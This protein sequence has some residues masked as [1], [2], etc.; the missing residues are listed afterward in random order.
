MNLFLASSMVRHDSEIRLNICK[1]G[2][3]NT[4]ILEYDGRIDMK[5]QLKKHQLQ[6]VNEMM[7]LENAS[8]LMEDNEELYTEM[9]VLG[10]K[11]GSGKTF[12]ILALIIIKKQLE[13]RLFVKHKLGNSVC[14][15]KK[16]S[17]IKPCNLI[18]SPH[19]ILKP[20]WETYIK[21]YTNLTYIVINKNNIFDW[22]GI[23]K[24]DIVLCNSR[25][26]NKFIKECPWTWSRVIYD[27]A[28]TI[29][30][31]ACVYPK[32]KFVWFVSSSLKNLLFP[33]GFYSFNQSSTTSSVS[34]KNITEGLLHN[35][36]IKDTFR[37]FESVGIANN[38]LKHIVLKQCDDYIDEILQLPDFENIFYKCK[39]S[40]LVNVL[41]HVV[42][43]EMINMM[44]AN[45]YEGVL[46][47]LGCTIDTKENIITLVCKDINNKID[48][49]NAKLRYLNSLNIRNNE[50]ENHA[51]K[52]KS[53]TE[54]IDQLK[55]RI[56]TIEQRVSNLHYDILTDTCPICLDEIDKKSCMLKCC[57]NVFCM[58]CIGNL[59]QQEGNVSKKCPMCRT[60]I[61]LKDILYLTK[62]SKDKKQKVN[63]ERTKEECLLD[64]IQSS[65]NSKFLI[66]SSYD[67]SFF[68]ICQMLS[69]NDLT[70][71][72]L[73]GN[74]AT[75]NSRLN[76]FNTDENNILMLNA[77]HYGCG[78][79][80][81][82]ATDL[83]FFHKMNT[84][85]KS[86]VIGRA[87]RLGRTT[88]LKVHHLYY[89]NEFE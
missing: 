88:N 71:A 89:E 17:D 8:I 24:Y 57:M 4:N 69:Q 2:T 32:Y 19:H 72:K 21:E 25:L 50:R 64:I 51:H 58:K 75:I 86:Q 60:N 14:I 46:E 11:V 36:F 85:I 9:G 10:N 7:K 80:L 23:Q 83:V 63:K 44:N 87:Q 1:Y 33:N 76:N 37:S 55:E 78:L 66:F 41:N 42:G 5:I 35:G 26:H 73:V 52:I 61:E 43:A 48:N 29:S 40:Y 12:C 28:D 65:P 39:N 15:M 77:S 68:K 18:V 67:Q 53:T 59:L 6:M 70:Y 16:R 27:E 56:D 54:K 62:K 22:E 3:L 84:E 13:N 20:V 81:T 49:L 30:I 38:I 45:N 34:I 31:P 82:N 79:N 74:Q 47:S